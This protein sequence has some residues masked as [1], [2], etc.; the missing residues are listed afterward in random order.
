MR[1]MEVEKIANIGWLFFCCTRDCEF[2]KWSNVLPDKRKPLQDES[3]S[4]S[5]KDERESRCDCSAIHNPT[6]QT[7]DLSG[8]FKT[9]T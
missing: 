1:W 8:L 6:Q 3:Q 7:D 9:C 5:V 2:F 4:S